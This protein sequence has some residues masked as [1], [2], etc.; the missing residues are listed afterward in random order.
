M[1]HTLYTIQTHTTHYTD[2]TY[3]HTIHNTHTHKHTINNTD[4]TQY[5][6]YSYQADYRSGLAEM[7]TLVLT[8]HYC[9]VIDETSHSRCCT[10]VYTS[11][12]I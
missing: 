3:T 9:I 8:R 12:N 10:S 5:T 7:M 4:S 2:N 1:G 6:Q 11:D